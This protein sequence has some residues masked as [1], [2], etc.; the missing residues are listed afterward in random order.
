MKVPS[1]VFAGIFLL[2]GLLPGVEA[3]APVEDIKLLE[4][5]WYPAKNEAKL[6]KFAIDIQ[7]RKSNLIIQYGAPGGGNM[8]QIKAFESAFEL[9]RVGNKRHIVPT[10]KNAGIS[11]II[12]R[13]EK[14]RLLIE[15]GTAGDKVLKG[16]WERGKDLAP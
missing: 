8:V 15:E 6:R 16:V 3:Q 9:K 7:I 11:T 4:G 12:Y 14:D 13:L 1:C 10:K 5:T 2:W